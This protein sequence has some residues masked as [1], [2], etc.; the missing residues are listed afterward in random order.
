MQ[1]YADNVPLFIKVGKCDTLRVSCWVFVTIGRQH[2][3]K[4][5]EVLEFRADG[6]QPDLISTRQAVDSS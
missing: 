5:Q 6:A 1:F 3:V 4:K 2:L